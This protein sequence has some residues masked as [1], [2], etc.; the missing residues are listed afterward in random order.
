MSS[1]FTRSRQALLPTTLAAVA[2]LLMGGCSKSDPNTER[3]PVSIGELESDGVVDHKHAETYPEAVAELEEMNQA[4]AAAFAANDPDAAHDP[5]HE[6][7]HVLDELPSLAKKQ[8]L[9][10]EA[11]AAIGSAVEKLFNAFGKVDEKFHGGEGATY[12]EVKADI[13]AA[14]DVLRQHL[15]EAP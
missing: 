6:V 8:A 5:L 15:P 7:G 14:M 1:I 12:D 4:I 3:P 10:D 9:S 13:D 2:T 11:L